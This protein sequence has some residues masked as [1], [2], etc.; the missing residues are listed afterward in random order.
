M[1]AITLG[2]IISIIIPS[3][4]MIWMLKSMSDVKAMMAA[5]TS[6]VQ[7]TEEGIDSLR[8]AKHDHAN[9]I[10]ELTAKVHLIEYKLKDHK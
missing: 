8:K 3:S 6:R 1:E 7:H 9:R 2:D 10:Q 5:L 4:L